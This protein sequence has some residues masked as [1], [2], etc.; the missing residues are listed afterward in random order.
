MVTV[1]R[2][3]KDEQVNVLAMTEGV[4]WKG[5]LFHQTILC[6]N[7]EKVPK[8]TLFCILVPKAYPSSEFMKSPDG[9][10]YQ[11]QINAKYGPDLAGFRNAYVAQVVKLFGLPNNNAAMWNEICE[12]LFPLWDPKEGPYK[13]IKE[14]RS[15][16]VLFRVYETVETVDEYVKDP[17]LRRPGLLDPDGVDIAIGAPVTDDVEFERQQSILEDILK[18]HGC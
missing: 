9:K 6:K 3:V 10:M 15:N 4:V 8:E 2:C 12:K 18:K 5:K 11:K 1:N 16:I 7:R 17:H 13:H 14:H